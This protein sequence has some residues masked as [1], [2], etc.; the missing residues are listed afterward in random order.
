MKKLYFLALL[1]FLVMASGTWA[2][3]ISGSVSAVSGDSVTIRYKSIQLPRIGD[4]VTISFMTPDG[5]AVE[6]GIWQVRSVS[7]NTLTADVVESYGSARVDMQAT[8][9]TEFKRVEEQTMPGQRT[10]SNSEAQ[11]EL[12]VILVLPTDAERQAYKIPS[13]TSGLLVASIKSDSSALRAGLRTGDM[14]TALAGYMITDIDEFAEI[15]GRVP[16]G[17]RTQ[18]EVIRKGRQ[19]S[20][21]VLIG[22]LPVREQYYKK[23]SDYAKKKDYKSALRWLNKSADLG[24][25]NATNY[26]GLFYLNGWGTRKNYPRAAEYFKSAAEEGY[27]HGYFN[28]ARL[29]ETGRGIPKDELLAMQYYRKYGDYIGEYKR[30]ADLG[31]RE[32]QNWLDGHGIEWQKPGDQVERQQVSQS[33][34][35]SKK[36][37][38]NKQMKEEKEQKKRESAGALLKELLKL[39]DT[40]SD[41]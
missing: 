18:V 8:I 38:Y 25:A 35:Q 4:S 15:L 41:N 34:D 10:V 23:G 21:Q 5:D 24:Y 14:I 16:W 40:M 26:L 11:K 7:G 37:G 32:A 30:A 13:I 39:R 27:L 9:R 12:G 19:Q 29:Y 2:M 36:A 22:E 31:N 17:T 1:T 20:F 28:L 3:D 33:E 6:V